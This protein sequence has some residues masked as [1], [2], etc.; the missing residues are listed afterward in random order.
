MKD[1]V[2]LTV[3]R[4]RL[5][6]RNMA[7]LPAGLLVERDADS[8][9]L[10]GIGVVGTGEASPPVDVRVRVEPSDGDNLHSSSSPS[11]SMPY[12]RAIISKA[13]PSGSSRSPKAASRLPEAY[14]FISHPS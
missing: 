1:A 9:D 8:D 10:V 7:G 3:L 13:T 6:D 4:E 11:R 2:H 5:C 14:P 12:L